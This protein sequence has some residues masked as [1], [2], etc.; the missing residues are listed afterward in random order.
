MSIIRT[1]ASVVWLAGMVLAGVSTAYAQGEL[2]DGGGMGSP[3]PSD[4]TQSSGIQNAVL[5]GI[6]L[7]SE[8][9]QESHERIITCYFIFRDKPTSYFYEAKPK[10][11]KLVFEFN[12]TE[13]GVSPIPS[14]QEKPIQGF[15]V[16]PT[17]V[18][19]NAEVKGL[20]PEWHDVV[21]VSFFLDAI[22]EITVKDEYSVISFSFTWTTDPGKVKDYVQVDEG[23][24]NRAL[25]FAIGGGVGAAAAAGVVW[26]FLQDTEEKDEE[27]ELSIEDLPQHPP[28]QNP[29]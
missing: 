8:Q 16:E 10:E 13:T 4:A 29:N 12:D 17:K 23:R 11:N 25:L 26:Y 5:E 24:R 9:G 7:S 22:P 19:V 2:F 15:R 28:P 6:Q 18:D 20:T 14:M 1:H 3:A 21:K 27:T